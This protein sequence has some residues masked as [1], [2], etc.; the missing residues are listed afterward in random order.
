MSSLALVFEKLRASGSNI[1]LLVPYT[2]TNQR[3]IT[4]ST[5]A[6]SH[7]SF[8]N[9]EIPSKLALVFVRSASAVESWTNSPHKL[10]MFGL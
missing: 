6:Y 5:R 8:I 2:M 9:G 10:E 4:K 3:H 7:S 1:K